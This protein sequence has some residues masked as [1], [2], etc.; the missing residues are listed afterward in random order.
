MGVA[1]AI[2][3]EAVNELH[4]QIGKPRFGDAAVD[5]ARDFRVFQA[6]QKLPFPAE[7]LLDIERRESQ[8]HHF[9]GSRHAE[10]AIGALGQVDH[11]HAA[12]AEQP[13]GLPHAELR[14]RLGR[15]QHG[16][17]HLLMIFEQVANGRQQVLVA[18]A[19]ISQPPVPLSG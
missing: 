13:D 16:T 12:A 11:A 4:H 9:D 19:L 15:R 10:Y 7:A 3:G 8:R 18:G 5:Q 17:A 1:I 6:G 2:H 14:Q